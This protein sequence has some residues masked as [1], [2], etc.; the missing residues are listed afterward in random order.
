LKTVEVTGL[1]A[2]YDYREAAPKP[3]KEVGEKTKEKAGEVTNAAATMVRAENVHVS[4]SVGMINHSVSP[5][6]TECLPPTWICR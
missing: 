5:A 2:D 6:R 4:G 3:E 1:D